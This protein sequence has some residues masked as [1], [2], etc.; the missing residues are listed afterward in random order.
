MAE[1]TSAI[2]ARMGYEEWACM[3]KIDYLPAQESDE[4]DLQ[5]VSL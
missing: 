1:K 5:D 4:R 2:A 3:F